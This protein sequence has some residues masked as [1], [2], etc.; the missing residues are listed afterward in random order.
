[1]DDKEILI[2]QLESDK[3]VIDRARKKLDKNKQK[4]EYK[5]LSGIKFNL[6][7]KIKELK[8]E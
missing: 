1:M 6:N 7:K 5:R 2:K 8:G 3:M 4:S